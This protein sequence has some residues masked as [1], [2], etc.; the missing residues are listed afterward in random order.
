M[1][2]GNSRKPE[3][4]KSAVL[5]PGSTDALGERSGGIDDL[6]LSLCERE[7]RVAFRLN[8]GAGAEVGDLAL[9]ARGDPPVVLIQGRPIGWVSDRKQAQTLAACIDDGYRISGEITTVDISLRGGLA[10]VAG[11]RASP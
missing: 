1:G 5:A 8:D 7:H 6:T 11:V 4:R 10:A 9:I 2:G 3:T